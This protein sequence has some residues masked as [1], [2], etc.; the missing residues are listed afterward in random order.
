[1]TDAS[2]CD[3]STSR[4]RTFCSAALKAPTYSATETM[5]VPTGCSNLGTTTAAIPAVD[6]SHRSAVKIP[7]TAWQC[8]KKPHRSISTGASRSSTFSCAPVPVVQR[9]PGQPHVH[10]GVRDGDRT[11]TECSHHRRRDQLQHQHVEHSCR[12]SECIDPR[13]RPI[14]ADHASVPTRAARRTRRGQARAR[15]FRCFRPAHYT[16]WR[17]HHHVRRAARAHARTRV[18]SEQND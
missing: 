6:V 16:A 7:D 4:P 9:P 8:I 13:S 14:S 10:L 2:T 3:A 12:I 18:K 15:Q 1:M 17:E 11:P 5:H